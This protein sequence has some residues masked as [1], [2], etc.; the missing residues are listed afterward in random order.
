MAGMKRGATKPSSAPRQTPS[1]ATEAHKGQK[2]PNTS[3]IHPS[4]VRSQPGLQGER[5]GMMVPPQNSA[6]KRVL[7]WLLP[8]RCNRFVWSQPHQHRGTKL[9]LGTGVGIFFGVCKCVPVPG[10]MRGTV[11]PGAQG[12]FAG[13]SGL[14]QLLIVPLDFTDGLKMQL[15]FGLMGITTLGWATSPHFRCANLLM[16]PKFLGKEGRVYVLS[17]VL[18]AIYKGPVANTWHNLEEVTRSLSCVAELQVN[19]SRQL[20]EMSTAPMHR[21]LESMA[22]SGTT[23]N[24]ETQNISRAFV[25]LNAEVA[26]N[27]GFDLRERRE[28]P[29]PANLST[30]QVFEKKTRL[31]CTY[32]LNLGVQRCRDWFDEKH[33]ECM[34]AVYVPI[35]NHIL[36]V[37]MTFKFLCVIV[38]IADLWC[39]NKI[40]VEGNFGQMYDMVNDTVGN[41]SQEFSASVVIQEEQREMLHG[42]NVSAQELVEEVNAQLRQH[43]SHFVQAVSLFRFLLSFTFLLVFISAF[44]YTKKY[45]QDI[46]Y[47]NMYITTY[48]RQIDAP[49][50][51]KQHKRTLLPLRQTELPT[52]IFPCR[53]AI[54]PLELQNMPRG[55]DREDYVRTCVP[56]A[57]L[58]LLCLAQVYMYRLRRV[59][60]AF[61]FPKREKSRVLFLYN[62]ML[63]QQEG[64]GMSLLLWCIQRWPFLRRWVRGR[65]TVC[66]APETH[67]DRLCPAPACGARYCRLCWRQ[68]GRTCLL[69]SPRE[70]GPAAGSSDEDEDLRGAG[71]PCREPLGECDLP[72]FCDGVSPHCPPDA[73]LQDGQPCAGGTAL[74]HGGACA[75]YEG[76]CQQLLGTGAGPVTESCMATLNARGDERGHCGQLPNS[77]YVACTPRDAG[78]GM[79][80]CRRAGT[81]GDASCQGTLLPRDE[82]VSDAAM[83]LPG[84]ACGPGKVCLQHRCQDVAALGDQQCQSKCHG[85]GVSTAGLCAGVL[86]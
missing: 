45:C 82:D 74:C 79:L 57:A 73:F 54:Q 86:D 83:V 36:C 77:S 61:F 28:P 84:T 31:R 58:A 85:R 6:L 66:E 76:Q 24:A 4:P 59:I 7:L 33:E 1:A 81:T 11:A 56:L 43:G 12:T 30:Q 46:C 49:R 16:A 3:K 80:Q 41:I 67:R 20:W 29:P 8:A 2:P 21:V 70:P 64:F 13:V 53:L 72:E 18:A 32:V 37:P 78:C 75:T 60:A 47:D 5:A 52:V 55:R 65:C 19:H 35:V 9:L 34:A 27:A 23:L 17:L 14:C 50:R 63:H 68:V 44:N 51:K 48:F 40:P 69:C 15:C 62:K 71:H 39:Q 38:K 22:R 10:A 42:V 25:G 26:S